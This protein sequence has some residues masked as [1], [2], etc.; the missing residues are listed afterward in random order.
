MET[1]SERS[2]RREL[3]G[4]A[5]DLKWSA[6]ELLRIADRLSQAGNEPDAQALRKMIS[7][8]QQDE[9]RLE[10]WASEIN[11]SSTS[12]SHGNEER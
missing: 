6:V 10:A 8:F 9:G 12:K 5:S 3:L 11:A 4:I 7:V 1:T 2:L